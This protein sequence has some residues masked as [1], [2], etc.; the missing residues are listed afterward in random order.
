ENAK[1]IFGQVH[2]SYKFCLL[3]VA[4]RDD[5]IDKANFA[6]FLH[7]VTQLND[8]GKRF[9]LTP[10]E[11]ALLNPNT[12]TCPI[13]RTRRDA[14][15][16]LDIYRRVPILVKEGDPDGNPWGIR[17]M[18][19]LFN[20]TSDSHLFRPS[21]TNGETLEDM[22]ADGW[23]LEGDVLVRGAERLLP[24]YEAKLLHHYDHRCDTYA[25]DGSVCELTAPDK[26]DPMAIV[27]PRYWV[28]EFTIEER[29]NPN[30]YPKD[31]RS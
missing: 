13:F 20:M 30:K 28:S 17:F 5:R 19:G 12:G 7:D 22:F 8:E 9:T 6:F 1:G 29:L 23:R 4:G 3:T 21:Q 14:E 11:I 31:G 15:I 24:V 2:R 10:S 25:S 27:L 16:T 26:H 18:Q